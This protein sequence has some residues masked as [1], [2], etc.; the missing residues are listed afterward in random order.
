MSARGRVETAPLGTG[1]VLIVI[2]ALFMLD[3]FSDLDFGDVARTWWPMILVVIAVP[4]LLDHRTLW[5]GLWLLA[6]GA[7]LQLIELDLFGLTYRNSWPL[8]LIVL[9]AGMIGRSVVDAMHGR[10]EHHEN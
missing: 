10:E 5:N 4:K 1:I 2:G 9:G 8:L 7:W 3:R 6:V